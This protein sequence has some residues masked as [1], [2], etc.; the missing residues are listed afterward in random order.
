MSR[1]QELLAQQRKTANAQPVLQSK[2]EEA[3][4]ENSQTIS[5]EVKKPGLLEKL[6]KKSTARSEGIGRNDPSS[7]VEQGFVEN[8]EK[9]KEILSE[10]LSPKISGERSISDNGNASDIHS[11]EKRDTNAQN[12]SELSKEEIMPTG[13]SIMA[14]MKWKKEHAAQQSN[15]NSQSNPPANNV[16]LMDE[17]KN[18]Q[19]I[20]PTKGSELSASQAADQAKTNDGV[21]NIEELK[22]NLAYL[23]N[24]IENKDLV[25]GVIRTIGQQLKNSPEL[26]PMMTNADVNLVVRGFRMAYQIAA[27]KKQEKVDNRKAKSKDDDALGAFLRDAGLDLKLS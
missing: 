9:P 20:S 25:G 26:T 2:P 15:T 14:Q 27:M 16:E 13:L 1:I 11:T 19:D 12:S 8:V 4:I 21:A 18:V 10:I 3:K 17:K 7:V 23:A 6:G 5:S 22:R 24:H